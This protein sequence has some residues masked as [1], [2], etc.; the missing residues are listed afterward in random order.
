MYIPSFLNTAAPSY[1]INDCAFDPL[2]PHTS[3]LLWQ[4]QVYFGYI[5]YI[6]Q[7]GSLCDHISFPYPL[8]GHNYILQ[9][10]ARNIQGL[11][12]RICVSDPLTGKC[13]IY[14]KLPPSATFTTQNIFLPAFSGNK[15]FAVNINTI[16]IPGTKSVNDVKDIQILTAPIDTTPPTSS[17]QR[18]PIPSTTLANGSMFTF[19]S[20]SS[21]IA[22]F[23]AFDPG[24]Q[25]YRVPNFQSLFPFLFSQ[26]IGQHTVIDNWANGWNLSNDQGSMPNDQFVI[27]FIPQYLEYFGFVVEGITIL[28]I[29]KILSKPDKFGKSEYQYS[30]IPVKQ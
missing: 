11:S 25:L 1:N 20:S 7:D 28:I 23:T 19:S 29:I 16:G 26:P 24:W 2:F 21:H 10:T 6:S 3:A 12:L 18:L 5:R 30:S 9:I 8:E 17:I 4:K 27:I 13:V 22:L 14:T 15:R